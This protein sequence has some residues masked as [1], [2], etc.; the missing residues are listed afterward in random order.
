MNLAV[1][2]EQLNRK[3]LC[4]GNQNL[5]LIE[6]PL[7]TTLELAKVVQAFHLRPCHHVS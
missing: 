1:S 3:Q 7:K 2:G 5:K 4:H 6:L